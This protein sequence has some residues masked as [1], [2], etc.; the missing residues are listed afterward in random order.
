MLFVVCKLLHKHCFQFLLRLRV[1]P[2]EISSEK[3][4]RDN[5]GY[6][7]IFEKG[8]YIFFSWNLH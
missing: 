8:L 5:K 2:R 3:V 7:G 6:Y 1:A 4:W